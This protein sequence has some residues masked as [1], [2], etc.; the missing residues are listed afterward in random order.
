MAENVAFGLRRDPRSKSEKAAAVFEALKMWRCR[1]RQTRRPYL[2]GGQRQHVALARA[3]DLKPKV[4]LLDEPLSALDRKMREQMQVRRSQAA[5]S[6][7]ASP[8]CWSPMIRKKLWSC[9]TASR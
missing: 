7:S 1:L 3:P 5:T 4:L 8:S 2:S 6:D 9:P